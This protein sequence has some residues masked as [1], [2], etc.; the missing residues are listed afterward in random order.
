[1]KDY[2]V[3]I[4]LCENGNYYTGYTTDI[5]KRY[6]EHCNGSLKCRYT[7]SYP[8]KEISVCWKFRSDSASSALKLENAIKKLTR[9]GKNDLINNPNSIGLLIAEKNIEVESIDLRPGF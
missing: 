1:M 6:R 2:Y 5:E 8:P 7:R 9:T 3:Y 4:L